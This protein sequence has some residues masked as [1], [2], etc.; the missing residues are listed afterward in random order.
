MTVEFQ[1]RDVSITFL[2][3]FINDMKAVSAS[4]KAAGAGKNVW[5]AT[6]LSTTSG[7]DRFKGQLDNCLV[8]GWG[9]RQLSLFLPASG[10]TLPCAS[11]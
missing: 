6:M 7:F 4:M 2:K 8:R 11:W 9:W 1:L 5:E 10:D 3:R